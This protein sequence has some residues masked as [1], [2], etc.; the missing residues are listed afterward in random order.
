MELGIPD[1][2]AGLQDVSYY[3]SLLALLKQRGLTDDEVAGIAGENIL[4]VFETTER[5]G[6][7]MRMGEGEFGGV[8]SEEGSVD[9]GYPRPC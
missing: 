2:P 3:P 7:E 1:P 9:Y 6:R 4:R 5:I 8:S